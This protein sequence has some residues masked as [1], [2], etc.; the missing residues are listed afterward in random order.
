M[1]LF[2]LTVKTIGRNKGASIVE[3]AAYR[4][5]ERLVDN[6]YGET[7]DYS[8]KRGVVHSEILLPPNAPSEFYDRAS[9]WNAVERVENRCDSR[10]AREVE[11]ALPIELSLPEQIELV[12]EYVMDNFVSH[13]MCA[14]IAIHDKGDGNPHSHILLT[15]RL[16]GHDGFSKKKNRD[17]DKR[18]YINLWREQWAKVQNREFEKRGLLVRVSHESYIKQGIDR[19]PTKHLGRKVRTLERQGIQTDRGNEN[20]DIEFRN[21]ERLE[22]ERLHNLEREYDRGRSM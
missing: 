5:G 13:G 22:K 1:A 15:T 10:L 6:Y 20:R 8:R 19:E 18:A 17:W 4:S 9:L 3:A 2:H 21:R 7:H 16:V 11:I 14:D 12:K